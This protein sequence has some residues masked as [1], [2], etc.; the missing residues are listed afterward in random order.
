M[1]HRC[2][3]CSYL[4]DWVRVRPPKTSVGAVNCTGTCFET[5]RLGKKHPQA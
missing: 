1:H 4:R 3:L 2:F 5:A